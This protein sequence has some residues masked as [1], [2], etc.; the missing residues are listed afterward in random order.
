MNT[1]VP[2]QAPFA[3]LPAEGN[4]VARPVKFRFW[5]E[6]LIDLMLQHPEWN[7]K[8]LGD[9]IGR[10]AV[11]VGYVTRSDMFRARLALR[12]QEHS[13]KISFSIIAKQQGIAAQSLDQLKEKLDDNAITK[14]ISARDL[15]E[16]AKDALD[17]IGLG[18]KSPDIVLQTNIQQNTTSVTVSPE[19]LLRARQK[20]RNNEAILDGRSPMPGETSPASSP[21]DV[22]AEE[23]VRSPILDELMTI[24]DEG[25][26]SEDN[27]APLEG[28]VLSAASVAPVE[29]GEG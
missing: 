15:H 4:A 12:R 19:A 22:V 7:N 8:Q 25:S 20:L 18:P 13:E 28:E 6:S 14:K 9:A 21:I 3:P 2:F 16:I 26:P 5:H 17:R 24:G 10:N 1:P 29:T 27:P 11:T 23:E